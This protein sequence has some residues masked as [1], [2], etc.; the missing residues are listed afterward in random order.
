YIFRCDTAI[1]LSSKRDE[2]Q[3]FE[4]TKF[5]ESFTSKAQSLV[6]VKY[7]LIV[8]T[9]DEKGAGTDANV[10]ITIFGSN[11]DSGRRQLTKKFQNLFERGQ[12]NRFILELLDLGDMLRMHVEHDNS[13][14]SPGWLLSRIEITNTANAVTTIFTCGKWLDKNKADGRIK[15]VIY[16]KY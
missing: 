7:E 1:P 12:T 3:T 2:F 9:G 8:I 10:F 15:R 6:P 4:C 16:P 5:I 13:G 14:L 11:G